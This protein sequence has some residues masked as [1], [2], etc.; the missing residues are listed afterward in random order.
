MYILTVFD[1]SVDNRESAH[2]LDSPIVDRY[3]F[4]KSLFNVWK[5]LNTSIKLP[6]YLEIPV[7][8]SLKNNVYSH[9]FQCHRRIRK[10][11]LIRL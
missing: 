2:N 6:K 8:I 4:L 9:P 10:T 5:Y 7:I 1:K 3:L 11:E